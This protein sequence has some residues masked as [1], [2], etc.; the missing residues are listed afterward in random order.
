[1]FHKT[2][3]WPDVHTPNH[4]KPSVK[5]A[6]DFI[7]YYKP[8]RFIQ[9]G[10]LCDWDSVTEFDPRRESDIV[11]IDDE[12]RASNELLDEIEGSLPK[13]CEKVLI[14]GNHEERYT[15]FKTRHGNE[16]GMRRMRRVRNWWDEYNLPKRGWSWCQYGEI[17]E[18]G[19][20][21]FTHGWYPGGNHSARHLN[22]YHKNIMYGHTHQFQVATAVG[23]DGLPIEAASIGTLSRF[24]LSYLVGKPPVN[25][26]HM[27]A[28]IDTRDSGRFTPHYT[29]IIDG[30][31]IEHGKEFDGRS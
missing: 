27:F 1:M 24:D 25:W 2:V 6:L 9:L 29:H 30:K 12:I 22:L 21:I 19:K 7:R 10:D 11:L 8:D 18:Y 16:L 28:Y 4:D 5:A 20:I 13:K 31:F 3:V 15:K 26:V 17:R 23:M 14:G